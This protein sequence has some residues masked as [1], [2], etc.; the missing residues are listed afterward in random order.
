LDKLKVLNNIYT[1]ISLHPFLSYS[2][3]QE[4]SADPVQ[5]LVLSIVRKALAL[6]VS[7]FHSCYLVGFG[8]SALLNAVVWLEAGKAGAFKEGSDLI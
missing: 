5:L 8:H 7:L 2:P 1:R 4:S 6:V 3:F